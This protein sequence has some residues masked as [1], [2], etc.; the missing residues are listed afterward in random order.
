MQ[1]DSIA[2]LRETVMLKED[3]VA[4]VA[5][6][7]ASMARENQ[8]VHIECDTLR[9]ECKRLK[10]SLD[11]TTMHMVRSKQ[12]AKGEAGERM[13][14]ERAYRAVCDERVRMGVRVNELLGQKRAMD[15][16]V[17]ATDREM[18]RLRNAVA[19]GDDRS[20][21]QLVDLRN[22]E[23]QNSEVSRQLSQLRHDI[24][25]K[26]EQKRVLESEVNFFSSARSFSLSVYLCT[27]P[28]PLA[29][30]ISLSPLTTHRIS[31]S[32]SLSLSLSQS[33]PDARRT[34]RNRGSKSLDRAL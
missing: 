5:E 18:V 26:E 23:R 16:R 9:A 29:H 10:K 3:E 6:D 27:R 21:L 20:R 17:A 33:P 24:T 1:R 4:A 11:T 25:L 2:Q 32:L 14:I 8:R 34:D 15:E 12:L 13:E 31:L 19:S 30:R 7:I 22:L 28:P